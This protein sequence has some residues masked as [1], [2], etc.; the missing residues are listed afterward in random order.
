M[1]MEKIIKSKV[2]DITF[3]S[4]IILYFF[5][6]TFWSLANIVYSFGFLTWFAFVPFLFLVKYENLKTSL[7]LSWIFGFSAY[8]FSFWWLP[9]PIISMLS[10]WFLPEYLKFIA[11]IIGWF[12]NIIVC[13][14]H[15]LIYLLI[16]LI[17]KT[18]SSKKGFLFYII[19]PF[20]ATV[21]DYFFPKLWIDQIGYSQYLFFHFSQAADLFG[22][23]FLTFI[24][25]FCNSATIILIESILFKKD[26]HFGAF[27]FLLVIFSIVLLS[28]YG[29]FRYNEIKTIESQSK[30]AKIGVVQANFS[31]FDK[32]DST[33]ID[34]MIETHN[35]LSKTILK[36][37]PDLIVWPESAIPV[38]I[39]SYI[40]TL[41][42]V[43]KFN[44]VPLLFGCHTSS[45]DEKKIKDR[46]FNSLVLVNSDNKKLD[47]YNKRKLLP[48][49]EEFPI[50][51]FDFIMSLYRI[52]QFDR[53]EKSKIMRVGDIKF[54]PNI[55]YEAVIPDLVRESLHIE[56]VSANLIINCTNDSWFGRTVEPKLHLHIA[57]FRS[58]ENRK[59]LIRSTC[60]GISAIFLPTG[61][62]LYKSQLFEKDAFV[63]EVPLMEIDTLYSKGGYLFVYLINIITIIILGFAVFRKLL[64]EKKK[65][66][67]INRIHHKKLLYRVW[68]E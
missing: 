4:K 57:G 56:G 66:D 1:I 40:T 7:F 22:V 21:I 37:S 42:F 2:N 14:F 20:V 51:E 6:G 59:A 52:S 38:L 41:D 32:R 34:N 53:G 48:F 31:G 19:I 10:A 33:K 55:C 18:I 11:Y 9:R 28:I 45:I 36:Y 16:V 67:L 47:E 26:I 27:L 8:I 12:I 58:I 60:T 46:F 13:A 25:F 50:R 61:E 5:C 29:H 43:K 65:K 62:I 54:S 49:V 64:F 39:D 30:K 17:A 68:M 44:S 15:G 24:I 35:E 63:K 23:P 3:I